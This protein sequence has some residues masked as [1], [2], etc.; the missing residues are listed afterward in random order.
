[1]KHKLYLLLALTTLL[2]MT[3]TA[4]AMAL[5]YECGSVIYSLT[6]DSGPAGSVVTVN[7]SGALSDFDYGIYWE[8]ETGLELAAGTADGSGNFTSTITIPA[9]ATVG[10]HSI[11]FF[12]TDETE[13]PVVCFR[14]FTVIASTADAG[15]QP[16]AYTA[17]AHTTLPSTGIFLLP[18]AGLLAAGAGML[19]RKR[20]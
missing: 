9:D 1:M 19:Y 15:V 17:A 10:V 13:N 6:P 8:T 11:A 12:G 3:F 4:T 5:S 7:G 14:T 2:M 18:A 20:R 16:D